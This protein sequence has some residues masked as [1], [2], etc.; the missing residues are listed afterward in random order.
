M[1]MHLEKQPK[2]SQEDVLAMGRDTHTPHATLHTLLAKWCLSGE[3]IRAEKEQRIQDAPGSH[4]A[5]KARGQG[6]A[7]LGWAL[8]MAPRE[9]FYSIMFH[10]FA[11]TCRCLC[12]TETSGTSVVRGGGLCSLAAL[13][14][15]FFRCG[16]GPAE[17]APGRAD[18]EMGREGSDRSLPGCLGLHFLTC[19]LKQ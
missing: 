7:G 17:P 11:G 14:S 1:K 3:N 13:L 18:P 2:T 19:F 8:E 9:E 10:V 12:H 16:L 6:T 15:L 4:P 5:E